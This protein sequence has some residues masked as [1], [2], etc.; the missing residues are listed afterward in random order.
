MRP[1][2]LTAFLMLFALAALWS[3]TCAT[4]KDP[5]VRVIQNADSVVTVLGTFSHAVENAADTKLITVA[6]AHQ[7]LDGVKAAVK[8]IEA[9]PGGDY[10]VATAALTNI[11]SVLPP[12]VKAKLSPYFATARAAL[13]AF[14]AK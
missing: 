13:E 10:A 11:E 1:K 7:I 3:T 2:A 5:K 4:A 6:Q 9:T 8:T 12:D 14:H